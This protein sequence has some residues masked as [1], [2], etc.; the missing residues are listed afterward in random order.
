MRTF[1]Q[2]SRYRRA[3]GFSLLELILAVATFALVTVGAFAAINSLVA[4]RDAQLETAESLQQLQLTN[5]NLERDIT[6]LVNRSAHTQDLQPEPAVVGQQLTFR[7]TKTGWA[8]PLNQHRSSL[9]RFQYRVQDQQLLRE[10]WIH[11]DHQNSVPAVS[12]VLLDNVNTVLFRYQDRS[13]QWQD[14]WPGSNDIATDLPRAIEV[15][16]ELAD[17]SRIRRVF[18][19][20]E[21]GN[22]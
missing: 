22:G 11:V 1:A 3:S 19:T 6:Q 4:A 8:N 21:A 17:S 7:G 12:T 5:H 10:Y 2:L 9:Q 20:L 14:S 16:I 18:L 13:R 15:I